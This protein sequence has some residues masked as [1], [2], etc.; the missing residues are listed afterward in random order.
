[1]FNGLIWVENENIFYVNNPG[2]QPWLTPLLSVAHGPGRQITDRRDIAAP[3][4]FETLL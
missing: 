1:M 4:N 2:F 3:R